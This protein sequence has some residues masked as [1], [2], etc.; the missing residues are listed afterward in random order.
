MSSQRSQS[1]QPEQIASSEP[2][3]PRADSDGFVLTGPLSY[4][5]TSRPNARGHLPFSFGAEFEMILRPKDGLVPDANASVKDFRNFNLA[6]LKQIAK[7]LSNAGMP[8]FAFDCSDDTKPDYSK[9]NVM[10]D[11][12][13]S[14]K[15]MCDGFCK[16]TIIPTL[17]IMTPVEIVIVPV[18]IVTPIIQANAGWVALIDHFWSTLNQNYEYRRDHSCGF[19]VHI[20]PVTQSYNVEQIR[21]L[22][23]AIIFW[24]RA[25]AECAP[26]S[27]QDEVLGFCKSNLLVPVPIA[28][29]LDTHS[30]WRGHQAAFEYIDKVGKDEVIDYICP[31]KYRA[32]NILRSKIDGAGSIEFR[33]APGVV[34]AKQAKHW[35]AFTMAFIELGMQFHPDDFARYVRSNPLLQDL[36]FADFES[37][38]LVCAKELNIYAQLDP[39]LRQP[40]NPRTLH[41]TNMDSASLAWLQRLDK[42]YQYSSRSA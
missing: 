23:K 38:L 15:H 31:D 41:I 35:I 2:V 28:T 13:L 39:R 1:E 36:T 34:N 42:D 24:E 27:R 17:A 29:S 18:E 5:P 14:K 40:D 37:K 16:Q 21:Q 8:A 10:L 30:F 12:S 6:L 25:T 11:G 9:W 4:A 19:H 20:S 32:W 22:A 26:P 7:L 3:R 33:R